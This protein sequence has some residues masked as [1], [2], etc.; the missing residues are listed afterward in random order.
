ME[1][2]GDLTCGQKEKFANSIQSIGDI[3]WDQGEFQ[4]A[5]YF[6]IESLKMRRDHTNGPMVIFKSL[7]LYML[8]VFFIFKWKNVPWLWF[9]FMISFR[10][11][12]D[13]VPDN[14]LDIAPSFIK[15]R[16]NL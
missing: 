3:L 4:R 9:N 13:V 2:Y 14:H 8:W 16:K 12:V 5:V 10:L 7:A 1:S 6:Y 11:R 15:I